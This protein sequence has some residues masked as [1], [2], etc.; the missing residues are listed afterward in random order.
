VV[1]LKATNPNSQQRRGEKILLRR[2]GVSSPFS[3][4]AMTYNSGMLL[5]RTPPMAQPANQP[6][7]FPL[8]SHRTAMLVIH[9]IGEQNPYE[10]LDSFARGV[11]YHLRDRLHLNPAISPLTIALKDWTQ[12]GI[13][14]TVNPGL[15]PDLEGRLDLFEYYW[16]PDTEDK[17][18]WKDTL[19][20]LVQTD[21]TPL[22]YFA[23]N[24]QEMISARGQSW[25]SAAWYSFKLF[26]R[27][28][29][30]VLLLYIP[31][32]AATLWLLTWLSHPRSAWDSLRPVGA[33]LRLYSMWPK[34]FVLVFYASAALM[35]W[36]MLQ[37][38]SAFL[39]SGEQSIQKRAG[40]IWFA[41]AGLSSILLFLAAYY[42]S[43]RWSVDLSPLWHSII[44]KPVS[45]VLI[46]LA[47]AAFCRYVLT[48]YVAD[49]A[50]YVSAD[51]KSKNFA[52]RATILTGSSAALA[53]LL[54]DDQY[55]RVILAGHS[56]GSVIAYDTVNELLAQVNAVSGP[57]SDRPV[58]RLDSTQL[59][60]LAGLLTF[61]SP[62]DKIYYFFREHVKDNQAI[63][64]QILSMLYSFRK[65][66]SG[67]DYM[68][69]DFKYRF[70]QLDNLVWLN[71]YALMDPVSAKLKFYELDEDNQR[72]FPYRVPG[73]AHLSYWGDPNFYTF[74]VPKLL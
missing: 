23:N 29:L 35:V 26:A 20:W 45:S 3:Y 5:S 60:K 74:F 49:V 13:R 70:P 58:L 6:P 73:L 65:T 7:V 18:S 27:E 67:R 40:A 46:A 44:T 39:K 30:R 16:A 56:L 72:S 1:R 36:F 50:V 34:P 48:A 2:L 53:R 69:F 51:E 41:L 22:R 37:S 14:L 10:S 21:L 32:L 25:G 59:K 64:A 54:A 62:L 24:L 43:V 38:L 4:S 68:P 15:G 66:P 63:R 57:A 9:G 47:V 17:L 55:D 42:L 31:L 71:A 19:K 33:A 11:F 8:R 61:G 12:A 28:I 52:A